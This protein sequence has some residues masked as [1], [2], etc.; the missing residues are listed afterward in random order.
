[1]NGVNRPARSIASGAGLP[2][3]AFGRDCGLRQRGRQQHV[4]LVPQRDDP[5]GRRRPLGEQLARAGVPAPDALPPTPSDGSA[6]RAASDRERRRTPRRPSAA[7]AARTP[8]ARSRTPGRARRPRG[9]GLRA[10][11]RFAPKRRAG[12]PRASRPAPAGPCARARSAT[13]RAGV[14]PRRSTS[15]R[16]AAQS[17]HRRRLR[18]A[19][20]RAAARCRP[21]SAPAPP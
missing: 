21:P 12:Q 18:R 2:Y 9:R 19:S 10:A 1:M 16:T 14:A 6:A 8:A 11:A 5:R 7:I 13:A 17:R 15:R 20:R 3:A 4:D